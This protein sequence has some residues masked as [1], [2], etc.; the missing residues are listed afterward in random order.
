MEKAL[1]GVVLLAALT[2]WQRRKIYNWLT[3]PAI[4]AGL[5]LNALEGRFLMSLVGFAVCFG[6]FF[7]LFVLG[8]MKGG[9]AK[10]MAAVGAFLGWPLAL[11]ALLYTFVAGGVLALVWALV[12][13]KLLALIQRVT[14]AL[15][16]LMTPGM[17]MPDMQE[18][19]VPRM[20]Y[21]LAIAAGTLLTLYGPQLQG[22]SR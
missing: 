11:V 21:G 14:Y 7:L 12:H 13:G 16:S 22:L 9:D 19:V 15:K 20:P 18:S 2:D 6:V 17:T 4:V 10:L 1:V 3:L 8:G 5:V